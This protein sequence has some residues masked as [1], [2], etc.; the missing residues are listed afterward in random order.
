MDK[1]K[2]EWTDGELQLANMFAR[3]IPRK[4]WVCRA[5]GRED[6]FRVLFRQPKT[7]SRLLRCSTCQSVEVRDWL[8]S[9]PDYDGFEPSVS[10]REF[11]AEL[12][13]GV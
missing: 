12:K 10:D 5:E 11:L 7:G 2:F 6:H 4:D 8:A 9:E 13:V 3:S 1:P